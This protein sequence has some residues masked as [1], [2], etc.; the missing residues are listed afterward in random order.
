MT[1]HAMKLSP[2]AA[3]ALP[4]EVREALGLREGDGLAFRV[5]NGKVTLDRIPSDDELFMLA[6]L[7]SFAKDW[8]SPE[9]CAAF[10]D[11]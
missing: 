10:D 11:L 2:D 8:L 6:G 3:I 9:D 1:I 5:E 4:D 7:E